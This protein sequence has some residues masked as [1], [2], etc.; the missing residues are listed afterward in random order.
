[1]SYH[2][3]GCAVAVHAWLSGG[4]N[5]AHVLSLVQAIRVR[6]GDYWIEP[7]VYGQPVFATYDMFRP[8]LLSA[9]A[10]DPGDSRGGGPD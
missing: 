6:L 10:D 8:P 2:S 1:M 7:R 3:T 5:P 4:C 9:I